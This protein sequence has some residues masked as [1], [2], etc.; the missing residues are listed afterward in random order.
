[1]DANI[2]FIMSNNNNSLE[3]TGETFQEDSMTEQQ[4]LEQYTEN[5]MPRRAVPKKNYKETDDDDEEEE[6][7]M[8]EEQDEEDEE[9]YDDTRNEDDN[10]NEQDF[11]ELQGGTHTT[12]LLK[13]SG[14]R[15]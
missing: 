14:A 5:V 4:M 3:N 1:M 2:N 7:D 10:T 11:E 13:K 15:L 6:D 9:Q 12:S 8:E